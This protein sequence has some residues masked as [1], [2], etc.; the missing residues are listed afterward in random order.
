MNKQLSEIS[1][2]DYVDTKFTGI[3]DLFETKIV[4]NEKAVEL[5]SRMLSTRFTGIEDLFETKIVANEKAVELASRTLSARLDLMNEFRSQLKDQAN[6]FFP[7]AEHEIYMK[8]VDKDIRELRESRAELA[9]KASQKAVT[10]S[11]IIAVIS[12]LI[13]IISL[14]HG[15]VIPAP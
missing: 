8:A 10:I 3:E 1:L 6:T 2:R 13:S 4:A 9:G 11:V 7:R 15:F 12:T 14:M 5:A